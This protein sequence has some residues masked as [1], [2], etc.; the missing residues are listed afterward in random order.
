MIFFLKKSVK[1][2]INKKNK[3]NKKK[4]TNV[5]KQTKYKMIKN[6]G[7]K[8]KKNLITNKKPKNLILKLT[9]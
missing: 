7:I 2:I 8:R 6:P 4:K 9:Q 5:D 1:K 3:K